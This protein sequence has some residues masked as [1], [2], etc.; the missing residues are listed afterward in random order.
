MSQ[1]QPELISEI[2]ALLGLKGRPYLRFANGDFERT[3]C[4]Q[5]SDAESAMEIMRST[6]HELGEVMAG[7]QEMM[8]RNPFLS[9]DP[10][11]KI[12]KYIARNAPHLL[13]EYDLLVARLEEAEHRILYPTGKEP[14]SL[15]EE[16]RETAERIADLASS[17]IE[18]EQFDLDAYF[19]RAQELW[20][21]EP[22][23]V[24]AEQK[25]FQE[26]L[27]EYHNSLQEAQ[28]IKENKL[29]AVRIQL[30]G[31]PFT[32]YGDVVVAPTDNQYDILRIEDTNGANYGLQTDDLIDALKM[33]DSRF[34]IDILNAGFDFMKFR[35]SKV[36]TGKEAE[37]F[38]HVLYELCPD[39]EGEGDPLGEDVI[40]LWWD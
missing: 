34:G 11:K 7:S 38:L 20:E 24:Q 14:P 6:S 33:I 8:V 3:D 9:S 36:P 21:M 39:L 31:K 2:D 19:K 29:A 37:E 32:A 1:I 28:K 10:I 40:Q 17:E 35:L 25:Q 27:E 13:E 22:D 26:E 4:Y 18:G 16:I 12:R 30:Q 15:P 23:E 5:W